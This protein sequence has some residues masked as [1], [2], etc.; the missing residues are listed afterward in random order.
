MRVE[1]SIHQRFAGTNAIA[2]LHV[3]VRTARD[4]V[5]A[6]FTV[7]AGNDQ[8]AFALGD[9]TERN[10]AVDFRHD[11]R[12]RRTSCFKQLDDARQTA[13][14]VF[15]LGGFA[16]NLRDDVARLNFFAVAHHQVRTHR[17]LVS[18]QHLVAGTAN[19]QT[20]LFLLV[21]RV[22]HDHARLTGYFVDFF[23]KRHAFL[24]VLD[25]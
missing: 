12:F 19:F 9:R 14:D 3:D 22:F 5:L 4:V 7:V 16:R 18:L 15:G 13:G 23:V 20:R 25:T 11:R 17:H 8:F 1:R 21:R 6:L 10:G 24:Q 2:F